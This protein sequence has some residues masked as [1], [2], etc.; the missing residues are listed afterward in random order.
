MNKIDELIEA[1]RKA[2]QGEWFEDSHREDQTTIKVNGDLKLRSVN[3]RGSNCPTVCVLAAHLIQ[4]SEEKKATGEFIIKAA[5][6]RE[7][8]SKLKAERDRYREALEKIAYLRICTPDGE[9]SDEKSKR[10][11]HFDKLT[12]RELQKLCEAMRSLA[13]QS[14]RR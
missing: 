1:G 12:Y 14:T 6:A 2:T 4:S 3:Y 13:L 7:A 8:I 5:N 9:L 10:M 11:I